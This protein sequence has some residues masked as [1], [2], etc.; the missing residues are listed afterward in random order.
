MLY[1]VK[2]SQENLV[3]E[4]LDKCRLDLWYEIGSEK[5][6]L[7]KMDINKTMYYHFDPT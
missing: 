3:L 2:T 5:D 4:V 7:K 6:Y 1:F